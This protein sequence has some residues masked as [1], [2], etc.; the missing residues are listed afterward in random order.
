MIVEK[1]KEKMHGEHYGLC[2]LNCQRL[3]L[4]F[5]TLPQFLFPA[6]TFLLS[7]EL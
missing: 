3:L 5:L 2:L 1:I 4:Y 7:P 6:Q